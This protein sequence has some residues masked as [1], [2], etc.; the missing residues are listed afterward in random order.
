[1]N[2]CARD[3]HTRGPVVGNLCSET[4]GLTGRYIDIEVELQHQGIIII[5]NKEKSF[6]NWDNSGTRH[7]NKHI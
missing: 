7:Q 6:K 5:N 2:S 3:S 1:M 4:T